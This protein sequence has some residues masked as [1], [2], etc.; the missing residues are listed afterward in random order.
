MPVLANS[1]GM[2]TS[3]MDMEL[4]ILPAMPKWTIPLM[5]NTSS[6]CCVVAAALIWF[7]VIKPCVHKLLEIHAKQVTNFFWIYHFFRW[8]S[9]I[10]GSEIKS[11]FKKLDCEVNNNDAKFREKKSCIIRLYQSNATFHID[12]SLIMNFSHTKSPACKS[13][14]AKITIFLV[15]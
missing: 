9:L 15:K 2:V 8:L 12:D 7:E 4:L 6:I 5:L 14:N 1:L 3:P 11:Y 13:T 10:I